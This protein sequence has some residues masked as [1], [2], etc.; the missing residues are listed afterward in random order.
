MMTIIIIYLLPSHD[1]DDHHPYTILIMDFFLELQL[2]KCYRRS[3]GVKSNNFQELFIHMRGLHGLSARGHEGRSEAG[4][5]QRAQNVPSRDVRGGAYSSGRGKD[6][7]RRG[8]GG[9][10]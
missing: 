6:E 8:G 3:A 5:I 2:Q 10:R 1:D 7:N 4:Q 9:R